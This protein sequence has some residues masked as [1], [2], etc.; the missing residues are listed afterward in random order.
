MRAR[1]V[2][3]DS[4]RAHAVRR[5]FGNP[6]TTESP[7]LDALHDYPDIDYVTALHEGIAV[8]AAS[9]YAQ[10]SGTT[11]VAN[12]H[13]A[14]GLGNGL[15]S[16]YGA[17]RAR[18]P[19]IVTA[20]QQDTRL[21]LRGPML[22][23]DLVAMAAPLTKWSVQVERADEMAPIM[24]RA[25]KVANDPP[26][27]PV[28]VALPIDVMEQD[29][30]VAAPA[31][32]VLYRAPLPEPE[33]V[34]A[35]AELFAAAERP[36]LVAGDDVARRGANE[37]LVE[38]A[39]CVG[40]PVYHEGL[41]QHLSFPNRHPNYGGALG[42][43]A[44]AIRRA[45][46][47]FDLIVLVGGPFFEEVW[48]EAG[49]AVPDGARLAQI[50]DD[51][52]TL[53]R[54]FPVAAGLL[55][56]LAGTLAALPP[57]LAER[58]GGA[59]ADA[60]AARNAS[61]RQARADALLAWQDRLAADGDALPMPPA[62][63]LAELADALPAGGIVVDEAITAGGALLQ[64]FD[65]ADA[66]DYYGERGGG[67]GQGIAGAL[68][69]KL[70]HPE[71]PV[72][73]VTGDGSAMYH[74]QALWTAAQLDLGILFVVLANREYRV[75]K[76]NL[77]AYRQRF[78]VPAGNRPYPHMDLPRLDFVSLAA[79]M[80]VAARRIDDPDRLAEAARQAFAS[81]RPCLLEVVVAGKDG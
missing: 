31:A 30:D 81:G 26:R 73:A 25:F 43:D 28:F 50:A 17:L 77:D 22:G 10:A 16:L 2:F 20:G 54:N 53:A 7:L 49:S 21:R 11:A 42:F 62:R 8:A 61:L 37:A 51:P 6:G 66:H 1:Q 3:L 59:F 65:L 46:A 5:V 67:I 63:A 52:H 45:L 41:R 80:G 58:G 74:I 12:V 68:G 55:G 38:L 34:L 29:T 13:V 60:A 70:A 15:G 44:A 75:L 36:C 19:M 78:D 24:A 4:L 39:E 14:P 23:H 47:P 18:S 57:V 56:D 64:A 9:F 76:H 33:G 72:L 40:A 35:L 32:P 48:F 27:G 79:G 69:V 71:R